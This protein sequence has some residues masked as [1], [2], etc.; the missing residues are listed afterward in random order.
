MLDE[1]QVLKI[2]VNRLKKAKIPYMISGSVAMN[3]Y[4][5]PRMT[6][7][8][9]IVV[10]IKPDQAKKFYHLFQE[11]FYIDFEEVKKA[12]KNKGM[13]NVIFWEEVVKVDFIVQKET[14]YRQLEFKRRKKV[15]IDDLEI[16]LVS[17]EDLVLSKLLWAKKSHSELQL[18][19]VRNLLQTEMDRHYLR[20]WSGVLGVKSLLK[21]AL[22][23]RY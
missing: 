9:D 19:D 2:V 12:I 16:F 6:R 18:K 1:F 5:Q 8:I 17:P 23:E 15:K 7:D 14:K 21:E 13:F 4:A 11:D 20:K 10:K 22:N 3:Y